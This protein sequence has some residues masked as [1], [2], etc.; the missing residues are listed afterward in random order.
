KTRTQCK[1]CGKTLASGD[2]G[3]RCQNCAQSRRG[4]MRKTAEAA[5]SFAVLTG[6]TVWK[7]V[8]AA[9]GKKEG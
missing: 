1:K 5:L 2:S 6:V 9:T 8:S 4:N 3:G 7:I